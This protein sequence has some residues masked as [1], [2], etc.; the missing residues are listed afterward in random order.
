MKK[1]YYFIKD[2]AFIYFILNLIMGVLS[3]LLFRRYGIIIRE[4]SF[5][6]MLRAL[7]IISF[8][9]NVA[10]VLFKYDKMPAYLRIILGYF[11]LFYTTFVVRNLLGPRFFRTSFVLLIFILICTFLYFIGLL[12]LTMMNKKEEKVMNEALDEINQKDT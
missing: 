5:I 6:R 8:F 2:L 3:V 11:V 1:I 4:I 10:F 7:F 12:I 9:I